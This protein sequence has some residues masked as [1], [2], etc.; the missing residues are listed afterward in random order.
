MYK[1]INKNLVIGSIVITLPI[2]YEFN[3]LK[4]YYDNNKKEKL[5]IVGNGY[6]SYYL[7]KNIDGDKY[8]KKIISNNKKTI[9]VAELVK[10]LYKE[11]IP[12]L[13]NKMNFNEFINDKIININFENKELEGEKN[14]YNYDKLVFCIGS[15]TND[16]NISGVK[17]YA[18]K[19]KNEEDRNKLKIKLRDKTIKNIV[20]IGSGAVGVELSS[21]LNS[22]GYKITIIEGMKDI[23]PGYTNNTKQEIE[24]YLEKKRNKINKRKFCKRNKSKKNKNK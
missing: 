18:F 24:K 8:N 12:Y 3:N 23:L 10:S 2:I 21:L 7:Q 15:E 4:N 13:A 11:E 16:F 14:K 17:E 22:K 9:H 1:N 20:V 6:A 19:F 5:I